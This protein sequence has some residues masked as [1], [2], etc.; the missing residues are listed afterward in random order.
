VRVDAPF[1]D[2]GRQLT[3]IPQE[4]AD[5]SDLIALGCRAVGTQNASRY[6]VQG[7]QSI[8]RDPVEILGSEPQASPIVEAQGWK[9][10]A[11]N[12]DI[13]RLRA[14]NSSDVLWSRAIPCHDP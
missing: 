1:F 11:E 8:P 12:P 14:Q 6:V 9:R 7:R 13:T 10:D 4:V 3:D 2:F 5:I